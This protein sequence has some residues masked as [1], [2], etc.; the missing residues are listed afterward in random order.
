MGLNKKSVDDINFGGKKVG[1]IVTHKVASGQYFYQYM[2]RAKAI[3]KKWS[4]PFI[5]LY[6]DSDLNYMVTYQKANYSI[7][8]VDPTGDG[9]HPNLAG[10]QIIAP[11]IE[12]WIKYKI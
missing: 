8:T 2:D 9:L 10:Y 12:N 7:T 3:C 1:F 4:I 5:D 11:K 6:E